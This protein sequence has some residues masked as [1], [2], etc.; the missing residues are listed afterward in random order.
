MTIIR[1]ATRPIV[2][3]D[4]LLAR[5]IDARVLVIEDQNSLARL[6]GAMISERWGCEVRI[7]N[8][9]AQVKEELALD[10]HFYVAVCD[11]NL[12]DAQHGEIIDEIHQAG[13]A[14][15]ALTGEFGEELR[16]IM[17]KKGVIDYVTKTSANA[18]EYVTNLVG[19]LHYNQ[20]IKVLV[21]DDSRSS[22]ALLKHILSMLRFH[23]FTAGDGKEALDVLREHPDI[24]LLLTDYTMPVMDGFAL[25]MAVRNHFGKDKLAI[26]GISASDNP[27]VSAQFLKNGA[28]DFIT[29]P[30]SYEEMLC[31]ITQNIEMLELI[32]AI[33]DAANRDYLTGLYNRRYFFHHGSQIHL[34]A[35][36]QNTPLLAA[37]LDIDFFKKINDVYGHDAGDAALKHMAVLLRECFPTQL[38]A[39]LG[40]EEFVL[41][42]ENLGA[43]TAIQLLEKFRAALKAASVTFKDKTIAFTVSVGFTSG[44]ESTIDDMLKTADINLYHAKESGRDRIVGV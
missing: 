4:G 10:S 8:T 1:S 41:L 14:T 38:V 34:D 6:L 28:N 13:I 18:Y 37:M 23:V 25:T 21:V 9:M 7:A 33:Q 44:L 39:R 40:G 43:E 42:F 3:H 12:P 29:K 16:D 20:Q 32:D 31:R 5:K 19:R 2:T 36:A 35:K 15:I 27:Q 30:F 26:I 11:L 24:R 17:Q 22:R